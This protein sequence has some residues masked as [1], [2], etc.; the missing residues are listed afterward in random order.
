MQIDG[1]ILVATVEQQTRPP[2]L[3]AQMQRVG[4]AAARAIAAAVVPELDKEL[5]GRANIGE[6]VRENAVL[7]TRVTE[8]V[9]RDI[10]GQ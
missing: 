7:V 10:R 8:S 9:R 3:G 2:A 1:R 6:N 5:V 4:T